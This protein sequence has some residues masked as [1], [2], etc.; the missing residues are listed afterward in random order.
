MGRGALILIEGL[1]RSGKTTQTTLLLSKLKEK[2][3]DKVKLYRFPG[4]FP[5]ELWM[6][7]RRID[8]STVIGKQINEYLTN[9]ANLDDHVIHLL[10]SSNRWELSYVKLN[11]SLLFEFFSIKY[12]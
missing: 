5:D 11:L 1:D 3:G 8:R 6:I 10:F 2:Y 12:I 4:I 7:G 9:K